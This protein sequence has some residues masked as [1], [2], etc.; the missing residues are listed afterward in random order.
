MQHSEKDPRIAHGTAFTR[1]TQSPAHGAWSTQGSLVLCLLF[2]FN[3]GQIMRSSIILLSYLYRMVSS[4]LL[5]WGNTCFGFSLKSVLIYSPY[6]LF[7]VAFLKIG[8][9]EKRTSYPTLVRASPGQKHP[10]CCLL[11]SWAFPWE[12]G[13]KAFRL[14][15]SASLDPFSLPQTR[16]F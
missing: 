15:L 4:R 13:K 3:F 16:R 10:G 7:K 12:F 11:R 9:G 1:K 6:S 2:I 5:D 8:W 14:S